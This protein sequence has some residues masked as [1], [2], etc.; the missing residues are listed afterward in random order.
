MTQFLNSDATKVKKEMDCV[1]YSMGLANKE[2]IKNNYGKAAAHYEN[3]ARSL[4]TLQEM[5]DNKD[6]LDKSINLFKEVGQEEEL[7][8]I[9]ER[10]RDGV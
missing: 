9:I 2:V 1:V 7:L 8:R 5:K 10:L 4:Y 3:I 6:D